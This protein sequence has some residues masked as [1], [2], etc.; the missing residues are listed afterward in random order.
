MQHLVFPE[1]FFIGGVAH[2]HVD[3]LI[4]PHRPEGV[5]LPAVRHH[6]RVHAV[7]PLTGDH[8][9]FIVQK[10]LGD[11]LVPKGGAVLV[12][13]GLH[14]PQ[15]ILLLLDLLPPPEGLYLAAAHGVGHHVY[16]GPEGK[17]PRLEVLCRRQQFL[18]RYLRRGLCSAFSPQPFPKFQSH[19]SP[20][21]FSPSFATIARSRSDNCQIIASAF[22]AAAFSAAAFSAAAFSD[23]SSPPPKIVFPCALCASSLLTNTQS[24]FFTLK[25]MP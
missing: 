24:F 6:H 18:A 4:H 22:S 10:Q 21:G 1:G 5:L 20:S 15:V 7:P 25:L 16:A 14:V 23:K 13:V 3:V 11:Q 8:Q 19:G 12:H 9:R 2:R 17:L